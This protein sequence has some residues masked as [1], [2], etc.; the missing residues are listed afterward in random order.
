VAIFH[1]VQADE[2]YVRVFSLARR[3]PPDPSSAG[4]LARE[5][6]SH[7]RRVPAPFPIGEGS[8]YAT[9]A[10]ALKELFERRGLLALL[11]VGK[12]KTLLGYLAFAVMKPKRPMLIVPSSMIVDTKA[13]WKRLEQDWHGPKLADLVLL[14]YE[15]VSSTGSG[16]RTL[17]DGQVVYPDVITRHS[18]DMIV[19]DE[20]HRFGSTS[21]AGT[22][23]V[24]RYLEANPSTIVLGM[25][26]TFIRRSLK[27]GAHI[28]DWCLHEH[29]PLPR[30]WEELEAWSDATDA[31]TSTGARRTSPGALLDQLTPAQLATYESCEFADDARGVICE[32]LGARMLETAGVIGSGD[33][34][35]AIP[36]RLD[37]LVPEHEDPAIEA[38]IE[39]LI[40]GGE[41]REPGSLPDGTVLP[42]AAAL[43]RPLNTMAYGFWLAQDPPPPAEYRDAASAWNKAVRHTIKYRPDLALDSEWMVRDAETLSAWRAARAAY[44]AATGLPEPPSVPRWFSDEAVREVRQWLTSG[45]GLVWVGYI[46]LG[47]RLAQELGIPYFAGGKTDSKGRHVTTL[48]KGESAILSHASV[49]T[50]TDGLQ[51]CHHR[52]LW[53]TAPHE[54]SLG[55]LHRPGQEAECV[56]NDVYLGGAQHVRRFWR[57]VALANNFAGRFA[58]VAQKL[59]YFENHVPQAV[60]RVGF[61]WSNTATGDENED[62]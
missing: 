27:D 53:M 46:A 40:R 35:L 39:M 30:E 8:I 45:P 52:Q 11:G 42:D 32:M 7:L 6:T 10:L 34:P 37:A 48:K 60:D 24:G 17:P 22:R 21:A 44:S 36:A 33:G 54:Q 20:V 1:S 62:A 15:K 50:G 41:G 57:S 13:A 31:R 9:Q 58:G 3:P 12:G 5:V 2:E 23:R 29:S 38:E 28:A 59:S 55:R 18:P 19:M 14:S 47:Q 4:A 56:L 16:A 43:A 49:G 51:F 26:G 25:T 61:R